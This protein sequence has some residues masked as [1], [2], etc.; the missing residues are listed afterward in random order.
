VGGPAAYALND[1]MEKEIQR[2]LRMRSDAFILIDRQHSALGTQNTTVLEK[3]ADE[4]SQASYI[5][6]VD[7]VVQA[8]R[9]NRLL[10]DKDAVQSTLDH[11]VADERAYQSQPGRTDAEKKA[12]SERIA[13]ATKSRAEIDAAALQAQA[14]VNGSD[15][16]IAAAVKDYDAALGALRDKIDQKKR[17]GG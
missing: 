11:F 8:D 3:L 14:A 16:K 4:V 6:H 10:A 9:L 12:S 17:S 7:L 2:R 1:A 13:A 5:V 15:Q